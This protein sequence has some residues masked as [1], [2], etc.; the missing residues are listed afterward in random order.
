MQQRVYQTK[1]QDVDN[2][3]QRLIDGWT[4]MQQSII[5][6]AIDQWHRR[7]H[8]CMQARKGHFEYSL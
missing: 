1:M 2:F 4:E 8:N 7:L 6:N 5:E 3:K